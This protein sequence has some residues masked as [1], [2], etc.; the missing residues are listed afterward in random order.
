[1]AGSGDDSRS[2]REDGNAGADDL[3]PAPPTPRGY[4]LPTR[5]EED[6][7]PASSAFD[8]EDFL[9]H[10]YRG[11][12]LLADNCVA[13]A[14]GE[15]E[16]ALKMQPRDASG[17]GLLGIVYFRLGMYPQA[18]QIYL[19]LLRAY[20]NEV[21][22]RVNA[23]LC[24]L[25]TGQ[26]ARARDMLAEVIERVPDHTRAW[27]Y[28]GLVYERLGEHDKARDAFERAG[29]PHMAQRMGQQIAHPPPT[30]PPRSSPEAIAMREAAAD[31]VR[32]IDL[33]PTAFRRAESVGGGQTD[34]S[35]AWRSVE[36]GRAAGARPEA[37]EP[38]TPISPL[39][40]ASA[41]ADSTPPVM[42]SAMPSAA[43]LPAELPAR[44]AVAD[45][46][47]M[48][49]PTRGAVQL[50]EAVVVARVD[51]N[52]A[53]RP[54]NVRAVL[55][56]G[57]PFKTEV[58]RRRL[59]G[60]ELDEPF[61]GASG[62][63]RWYEGSGHVVLSAAERARVVALELDDQLLYLR[64]ERIL[65]F[66]GSARYENGR[67]NQG[68]SEPVPMVQV[69][70]QGWVVFESRGP[71]RVLNILPGAGVLVEADRVVGWSGRLLPRP[72]RPEEAP[73]A[74]QRFVRFSGEGQLW[75]EFAE[76]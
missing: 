64:E 68:E 39:Q 50:A 63:M 15:L 40:T 47:A 35:G 56:D 26:P 6:P 66:A 55:S 29:Q 38:A 31:A 61:G 30:P 48:P 33:S 28:L 27:G 8:S 49:L 22:P 36:L 75:L 51:P 10:L 20:P 12:E 24:Y 1:M 52:A 34:Q 44:G 42:P 2:D 60:R 67:F 57:D 69:S 58:L 73:T 17:Q 11:S 76:P 53:V 74:G 45:R 4:R 3:D 9:F 18:I 32:E 19:E 70:G 43:P 25:K 54:R 72:A 23:A 37:A 71:M 7:E 59:R 62:A 14:K 16:E 65:A 5:A 41:I 13:E 46:H 21:T